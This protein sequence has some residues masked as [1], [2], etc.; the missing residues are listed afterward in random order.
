MFKSVVLLKRNHLEIAPKTQ[1]LI[2]EL[3]CGTKR[4]SCTRF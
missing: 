4:N 1:G 2:K 3:T